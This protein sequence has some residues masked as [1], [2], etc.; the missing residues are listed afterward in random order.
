M[1]S[2]LWEFSLEVVVSHTLD[3]SC[4][5]HMP[6]YLDDTWLSSSTSPWH[7]CLDVQDCC[8]RCESICEH[9]LDIFVLL[10]V[11]LHHFQPTGHLS[12][13]LE[14]LLQSSMSKS[15]LCRA[16]DHLYAFSCAPSSTLEALHSASVLPFGWYPIRY[17]GGYPLHPHSDLLL[18][19]LTSV[20]ALFHLEPVPALGLH[21]LALD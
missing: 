4:V 13:G 15:H 14:C 18:L 17:F 19:A 5:E 3:I 21:H 8:E 11:D 9:R 12:S 1:A 6:T 2:L 16:L 7:D 20:L 10:E